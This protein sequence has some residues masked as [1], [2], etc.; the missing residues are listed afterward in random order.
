MLKNVL[1]KRQ[2]LIPLVRLNGTSD[3]KWENVKYNNQ[4]IFELFHDI[5]FYDY[6]K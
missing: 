3:I 6:T 5:Q 4:T 1:T 2:N